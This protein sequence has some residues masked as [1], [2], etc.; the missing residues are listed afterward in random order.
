MPA[1][2]TQAYGQPFADTI[3]GHRINVVD[4]TGPKS[5]AGG[6][7]EKIDPAAF[8]GGY[9][10]P[11]LMFVVG[12]MSVSGTY[13]VQCEPVGTAVTTWVAQYYTAS[14]GAQ[15]GAGPTDLSGETFKLLGY[16]V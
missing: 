4:W 11:E 9:G 7:G 8:F 6:T 14:T 1:A 5:Y 10:A 12:S 15:L 2:T 3:G 16:G 13:I